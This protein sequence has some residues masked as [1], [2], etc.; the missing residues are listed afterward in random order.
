MESNDIYSLNKDHHL[1]SGN[2]P[3]ETIDMVM[4]D[5]HSSSS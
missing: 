5:L 1:H 2:F 4:S 3:I